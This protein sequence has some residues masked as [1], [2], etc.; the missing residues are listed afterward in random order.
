[1]RQKIG[2][3]FVLGTVAFLFEF[4]VTLLR[5]FKRA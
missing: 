3:K 2:D 4:A 5:Q 1:M